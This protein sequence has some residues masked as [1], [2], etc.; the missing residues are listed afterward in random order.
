MVYVVGSK[1]RGLHHLRFLHQSIALVHNSRMRTSV[2]L[3]AD[4]YELVSAYARARG[5]TLGAAISEL[6]RQ[7]DAQGQACRS[8]RLTTNE[9]GYLE[10]AGGDALTPEMVSR[11][12][13]DAVA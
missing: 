9:H 4:A 1:S 11:L 8:A 13:E 7:V 12:S 6:V 10:I 5:I 3:E 2:N